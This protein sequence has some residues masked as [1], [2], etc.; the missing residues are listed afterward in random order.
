MPASFIV[1][2][3]TVTI[4]FEWPNIVTARAQEIVG[5]AALYDWR[6]GLGPTI[7]DPENPDTQIQK[8]WANLTNQEK[9]TMTFQAAQRLLIAQAQS[10]YVNTAQDAARDTAIAYADEE[11]QLE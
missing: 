1:T 8:P 10:A 6:R 5:N 2:G 4:R 11:Y 9:L 7:P 3:S